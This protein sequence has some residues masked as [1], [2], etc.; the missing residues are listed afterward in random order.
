[1]EGLPQP[2]QNP[3]LDAETRVPILIGT[4]VGFAALSLMVV[5]LRLYTR[6]KVV[7]A[8]GYDD[9]TIFI[10]MLL[11]IAVSVVTILRMCVGTL[12]GS[13]A[14]TSLQRRRMD[15]ASTCGWWTRR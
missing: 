10:A 6:A 9:Y 13:V 8:V 12:L 1:M 11:S 5:L 15:L 3:E 14:L 4:S 2:G 7:H